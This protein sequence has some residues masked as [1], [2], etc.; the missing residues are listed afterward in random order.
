MIHRSTVGLTVENSCYILWNLSIS[1]REN[2]LHSFPTSRN[3]KAR[4][5]LWKPRWSSG[6][7]VLFHSFFTSVLNLG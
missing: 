1:V 7:R 2:V 5:F 4:L 3:V 6:S